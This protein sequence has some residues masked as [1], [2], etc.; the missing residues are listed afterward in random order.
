MKFLFVAVVVAAII[1]YIGREVLG[2]LRHLSDEELEDF[3]AGRLEKAD[4]KAFRRV[5][6]H[7]GSCEDCR[8]RLDAVRNERKPGP[9]SDGPFIERKY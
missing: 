5:S 9:G 1:Y 3:W 6:E 2:S 7:L 4:R 8:D